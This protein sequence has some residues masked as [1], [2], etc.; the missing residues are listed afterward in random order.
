MNIFYVI[1]VLIGVWQTLRKL[2]VRQREPEQFPNVDRA[3]FEAWKSRLLF[4]YNL[5]SFACFFYI[6]LD[7]ALPRVAGNLGASGDLIRVLGFSL[8]VAWISAMVASSVVSSRARRLQ[9]K[10]GIVLASR[11][12]E[13]RGPE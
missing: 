2:D 10:L 8:F 4:A 6:P 11:A 9:Q 12:P 7:L 3:A 5:G 1:A 13:P